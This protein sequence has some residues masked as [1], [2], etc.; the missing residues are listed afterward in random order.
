[1]PGLGEISAFVTAVLWS[2]SSI[3]FTNATLRVGTIQVNVSRLFLALIY[4]G[5][6]ILV[7]GLHVS[8]STSQWRNLALSGITGLVF[9]DTFLF[10]AFKENGARVSMLVMSLVPA[11]SALMAFLV[12]GESLGTQ[13]LIGMAVTMGG[14]GLVVL[15]RAEHPATRQSVTLSGYAYAILGAVGQAVALIFAKAAFNEGPIHGFVATFVRIL[16]S[17]VLLTPVVLVLRRYE[18]PFRIY[19]QDRK[20]LWY[21]V[22]GS[23]A[24]PF[25][26]ITF[27]LVAI[28]YTKIGIAATIMA[29]PP[30]LMLP[31]VRIVYRE[32]LTWKSIAGAIIA[33]AG[34][35]LLMLR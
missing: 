5:L 2:G 3:M 14:I 21:T 24:G 27:S 17:V 26:G 9:G 18:N 6:T 11:M 23:I 8:L 7:L 30:V 20:A 10:R 4:L 15:E 34:V 29:I 35:A 28:S 13:A 33:V 16:V 22:G 19:R 12:L 1:M 31:L 25:L 32:H